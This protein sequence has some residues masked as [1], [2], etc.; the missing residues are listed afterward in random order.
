MRDRMPQ[1]FLDAHSGRP[2]QLSTTQ[3]QMD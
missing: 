3:I 2:E 1:A